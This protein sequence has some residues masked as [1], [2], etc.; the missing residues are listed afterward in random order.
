MTKLT[1]TAASGDPKNKKEFIPEKGKITDGVFVYAY[2]NTGDLKY[3][4]DT[5]REYSIAVV[6]DKKTAKAF[7]KQYPKNG[8]KEIDTADFEDRYKIPPPLPD[9]DE[10]FIIKFSADV[11]IKN[12]LP[13]LK[14][15]AG[16]P[17]PY[18]W[19]SRPKALVKTEGGVKDV[20]LDPEYAI[21]NG[22]TGHVAFTARENSYGTFPK[23]DSVLITELVKYEKEDKVTSSEWG[24]VVGGYQAPEPQAIAAPEETPEEPEEDQ[25]SDVPESED[26]PK[27]PFE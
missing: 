9:E 11:S 19:S 8:Y 14:L 2:L 26:E 3:Q 1:I 20:T 13:D 7:K 24:E 16:D 10:Q 12:D 25:S 22:T 27:N 6:V 4:S 15:K 23:M 17:V 21:G 18:K 5:D